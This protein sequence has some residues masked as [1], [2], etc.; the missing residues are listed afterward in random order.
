MVLDC[1]L[2][3]NIFGHWVFQILNQEGISP[4]LFYSYKEFAMWSNCYPFLYHEGIALRGSQSHKDKNV[5]SLNSKT[6][7][8]ELLKR[9]SKDTG[10]HL[11]PIGIPVLT[12]PAHYTFAI[13]TRQVLV[14]KAPPGEC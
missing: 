6:D 2:F 14:T 8:K 4:G 12:I 10:L 5:C 9:C 3:K 11:I 7:Y 13:S 1:K